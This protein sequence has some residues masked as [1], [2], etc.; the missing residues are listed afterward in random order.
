MTPF[1]AD[2][3]SAFSPPFLFASWPIGQRNAIRGRR[4][5]FSLQ[6]VSRNI[7]AVPGKPLRKETGTWAGDSEEDVGR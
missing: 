3:G 6:K 1:V 2:V 5:G 7:E 4:K